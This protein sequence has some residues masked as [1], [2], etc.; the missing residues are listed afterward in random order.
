MY[1]QNQTLVELL[2]PVIA[3]MGYELLGIESTSDGRGTLLRFYIDSDAG[4]TLDDC[5]RVS[6]QVSGVLDVNDPVQGTYRLEISSP[7]L[8]RPL[9]TLEQF[10]RFTGQQ[11][12]VK[13]YAKLEGRKNFIGKVKAVN[14]QSIVVEADGNEY[15]IPA[16]MIEKAQLLP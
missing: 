15:A 5:G 1:K 2:G 9:F 7:G 4:I 13:L 10:K 11:V 12:R 8:A 3:S 14:Q 16:D 6:E